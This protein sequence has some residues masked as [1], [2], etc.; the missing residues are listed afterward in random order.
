MF[1]PSMV[2][3]FLNEKIVVVVVQAN[4]RKQRQKEIA[5]HVT[6]AVR[7]TTKRLVVVKRI[8]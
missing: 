8:F 7:G 6:T 1:S 5:I 4:Q 2:C 3:F